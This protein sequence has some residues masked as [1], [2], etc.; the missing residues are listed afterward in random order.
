MSEVRPS[1]VVVYQCSHLYLVQV[2]YPEEGVWETPTRTGCYPRK[3]SWND[4]ESRKLV[5][6]VSRSPLSA[7]C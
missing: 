7:I 6:H 2:D 4:R 1:N 3:V 5:F